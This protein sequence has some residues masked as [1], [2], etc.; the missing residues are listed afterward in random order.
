MLSRRPE[1]KHAT[2]DVQLRLLAAKI[3]ENESISLEEWRKLQKFAQINE[4]QAMDVQNLRIL[5]R[6]LHVSYLLSH[7]RRNDID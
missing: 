6:L 3:L 5:D 7:L 2:V 4:E 1:S